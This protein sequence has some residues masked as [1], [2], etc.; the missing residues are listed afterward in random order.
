MKTPKLTLPGVML[1]VAIVFIVAAVVGP[2]VLTPD[3]LNKVRKASSELGNL[4]AAIL[5]MEKA[6]G[7]MVGRETIDICLSDNEFTDLSDCA[8]GLACNDGSYTNWNGPYSQSNGVDPWGNPYYIDGDYYFQD[9]VAR[10]VGSRGPN[11]FQEYEGGD[12]IVQILCF[13]KEKI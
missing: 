1:T 8:L 10:V 9:R 4:S 3:R 6:T 2:F 12:D 13:S 5:R 11:G 7:Q